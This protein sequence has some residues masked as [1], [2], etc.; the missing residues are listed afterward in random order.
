ME[1]YEYL[2]KRYIDFWNLENHD[3]PLICANVLVDDPLPE[4]PAPGSL[5][6]KWE[7]VDYVLSSAIRGIENTYF[8]GEALPY[9]NPNL[10]PDIL[11]AV[12]GCEIEYGEHTSWATPCVS[13]WDEHPELVFDENNRWWKKIAEITKAAIENAHGRYLV[14]ITDLHPGTDGLVSLRGPRELCLDLIEYEGNLQER[15]DQIFKIYVEMFTRLDSIIS[16]HQEGTNNWMNIWHPEKKWYVTS[17]DFSCMI[18]ASDFEK[19]VVP[20]LIDELNF[21]DASIYH[22]DGPGALR[23][24]DRLLEL[25]RLN[26]IQWV[27]GA[28]QPGPLHWIPVYKKIQAAGRLAQIPCHADE[29]KTLCNELNPEGLQLQVYGLDNKSDV[30]DLLK[31]AEKESRR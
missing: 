17:N 27:F 8:G 26:G 25:P 29:V 23:H 22:L 4:I 9:F 12:A 11:G 18:S 14:G 13:D 2:K 15:I 31:L 1:N 3:R 10:G 21:L 30:E 6:E 7:N 5:K 16:P 28:G 24:L 19:L 20:A